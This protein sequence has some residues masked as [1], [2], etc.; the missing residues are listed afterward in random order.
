MNVFQR[1]FPVAKDVDKIVAPRADY[2]ESVSKKISVINSTIPGTGDFDLKKSELVSTIYTC[3]HILSSNISRAPLVIYKDDGST[4]TVAK[5]HEYFTCLRYNPQSIYS[6]QNW[7][8]LIVSHLHFYGNAYAVITGK[9]LTVIH[10][11]LMEVVQGGG[12]LWY[13]VEGMKAPIPS[14]GVLHFRLLSKDGVKGLSPIQSL[15]QEIQ[16]QTKAERTVEKFYDNRASSPLYLQPIDG[17]GGLDRN[18]IKELTDNWTEIKNGIDQRGIFVCPPLMQIKELRLT[19]DDIKF[20][21]SAS[22]TEASIASLFGIPIFLL[23]KSN[24]NYT[25][26]EQQ[27]LNFKNQVLGSLFNIIRAE[28]ENKLLSI[29]EKMDGYSIEFDMMGLIETDLLT[30]ANI[31]NLYK[32][33][34]V[35]SLNEIRRETNREP[36]DNPNMN[37]HFQ[38]MQYVPVEMMHSNSG[39][40]VTY[41][42]QNN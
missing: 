26:F 24:S 39:N 32:N 5:E 3:I 31:H 17:V 28:L 30:R 41:V 23:G 42:N 12:Q 11:D 40:T 13:W 19:A 37:Y 25:N 18:K 38:Q 34:G 4:K 22:Y 7:I 21:E 15:K 10:P 27:Q 29:Q 1:L 16:I 20:L 2:N 36:I 14:S 33:M 8:S 6:Y 35:L 9:E